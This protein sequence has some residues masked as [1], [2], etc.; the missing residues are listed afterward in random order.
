MTTRA[1]MNL[2]FIKKKDEV[3]YYLAL[4]LQDE[5]AHAVIFE[6]SK[7]VVHIVGDHEEY[8]PDTIETVSLEQLLTALDKAVS[9]AESRLPENVETQKTIFGVKENWV[10]EAKIKKNI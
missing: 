1:F 5:K 8:F 2:P 9:T 4:L 3:A 6:E 10:H 7:G